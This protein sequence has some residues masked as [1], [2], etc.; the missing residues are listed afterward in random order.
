MLL[1]QE[2]CDLGSFQDPETAA[3]AHDV[4]LLRLRGNSLQVGDLNYPR[5]RYDQDA[6]AE[7]QQ[8]P[9]AEYLG[10]LHRYG[11]IGD[12]RN[13]RCIGFGATHRLV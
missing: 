7:V 1:L 6:L 12:R 3:R 11:M 9:V 10:T 2:Q 13:S 8:A 5:G 4:A